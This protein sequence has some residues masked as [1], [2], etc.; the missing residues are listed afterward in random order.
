MSTNPRTIRLFVASPGDVQRERDSILGIVNELNRTCGWLLGDAAPW[1]KVRLWET[2]TYPDA[3][4]AQALIT[5]QIGQYD[6]F[7]GV[8][9]KRIGTPSDK[10]ESGTIEEFETAYARWQQTQLPHICFY[11]NRA[12]I[13]PPASI[14]EAEQLLGVAKFRERLGN[15]VLI[16][17]YDGA[18]LFADAIRPNLVQI[19]GRN[20]LRDP[21][22][23]LTPSGQSA[24]PSASVAHNVG[25]SHTLTEIGPDDACYNQRAKYVGHSGTVIE[26]EEQNGWLRGTFRF[27][28]PLI[29][30][31]NRV[32]SFL[33]FQ[34]D[35]NALSSAA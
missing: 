35:S 1:L 28:A 7:I 2:D 21:A 18:S 25:R 17:E 8:L 24:L 19:I 5:D 26:A 14:S 15:L 29:D 31:D 32:Y 12:A 20:F 16:R 9:W 6:I 13:A 10:A 4:R 33:Q 11:F 3:G 30:G 22:L 34:V 27:D 23:A